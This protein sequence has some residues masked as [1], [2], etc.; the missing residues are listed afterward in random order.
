MNPTSI[1]NAA[2]I[3]FG[4]ESR[5]KSGPRLA[6]AL[7]PENPADGWAVQR[8]VSDLRME[9]QGRPVTGWKCGLPNA[10]RWAVAALHTALQAEPLAGESGCARAAAPAGPDGGARVEPEL[11][12]MLK[13]SL[14]AR[15][16]AYTPAEV[17][18][19][20]GSVHLAIEV[21]G[22]RYIDAIAASGPEL[23][24]DSL[25]HQTLVLGPEVHDLPDLA[26]EPTLALSINTAG[27]PPRLMTGRHPDG[28]PRKPLY[29]LAEFLRTQ[30]MGLEAGQA[31]ITGSFAGA[32][33]LPFGEAA[34]LVFGDLGQIAIR[35]E[36]M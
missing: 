2:D 33:N 18:A 29:W 20:I 24:A 35:L 36:E 31:V 8:R 23:M 9:L 22:S 21:L 14:P 34:T 11:A 32:I 3:L 12:F 28:D 25:W 4:L 30:G 19:V 6:L 27:N 15:P 13:T 26:A 16:E 5:Q 17:D 7:R 1:H 10:E